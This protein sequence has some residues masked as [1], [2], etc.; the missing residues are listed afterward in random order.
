MSLFELL[1]I[2]GVDYT[3]LRSG[4]VEFSDLERRD[5][6][7]QEISS[8]EYIPESWR[9]GIMMFPDLYHVLFS[10]YSRSNFCFNALDLSGYRDLG[11][12]ELEFEKLSLD[13]RG[14]LLS[15]LNDFISHALVESSRLMEEILDT[16]I[17]VDHSRRMYKLRNIVDISS[18]YFNPRYLFRWGINKELSRNTLVRYKLDVIPISLLKLKHPIYN[19][20]RYGNT[21]FCYN[22]ELLANYK[23]AV[24]YNSL[25]EKVYHSLYEDICMEG[26]NLIKSEM[27]RY[28]LYSSNEEMKDIIEKQ[29]KEHFFYIS[30]IRF[31]DSDSGFLIMKSLMD[32]AIGRMD[33]FVE[34]GITRFDRELRSIFEEI[35]RDSGDFINN[36]RETGLLYESVSDFRNFIFNFIKS[37]VYLSGLFDNF[38]EPSEYEDVYKHE[39]LR[40]RYYSIA[41]DTPVLAFAGLKIE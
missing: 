23:G 15:S 32:Y 34:T 41:E 25:I 37:K 17:H 5:L 12:T 16:Y 22:Y 28:D 26:F 14:R 4:L 35:T 38:D 18:D 9:A 11:L 24:K 27:M 33:I 10:A 20:K 29:I 36:L 30:R 8:T 13:L 1:E 39:I 2:Y 31:M 21:G 40:R 19:Y 3:E 6:E 7:T